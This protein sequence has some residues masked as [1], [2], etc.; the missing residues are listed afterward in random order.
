MVYGHVML[1]QMDNEMEPW[2]IQGLYRKYLSRILSNL[3]IMMLG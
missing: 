2:A 1:N 3:G